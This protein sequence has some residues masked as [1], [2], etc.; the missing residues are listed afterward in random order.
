MRCCTRRN[1]PPPPRRTHPRSI[2]YSA[3]WQVSGCSSTSPASARPI[4][5]IFQPVGIALMPRDGPYPC[6]PSGNTTVRPGS[7]AS[8][9]PSAALSADA[10][11]RFCNGEGSATN[12][13]LP[14]PTDASVTSASA[15]LPTSTW[16]APTP[17]NRAFPVLTIF[18]M[19]ESDASISDHEVGPPDRQCGG[20][21]RSALKYAGFAPPIT[22]RPPSV[23]TGARSASRS[24]RWSRRRSARAR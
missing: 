8:V 12:T 1:S 7:P 11:R 6:T 14:C 9:R 18:A 4:N 21:S 10:S 2:A 20:E 24:R 13:I 15:V 23:K 5:E 17:S 22:S 16:V 3:C 19:G